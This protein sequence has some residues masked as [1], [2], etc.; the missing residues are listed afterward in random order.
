[1]VVGSGAAAAGQDLILRAFDLAERHYRKARNLKPKSAT[2]AAARGSF[3]SCVGRLI[4]LTVIAPQ[5]WNI[6][7]WHR[8]Q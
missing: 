3:Y 2:D 5:I 8:R 4:W 1:L 6:A 7:D